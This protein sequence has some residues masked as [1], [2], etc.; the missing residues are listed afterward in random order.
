M[1]MIKMPKMWTKQ[2]IKRTLV[3]TMRAWKKAVLLCSTSA[4]TWCS[5]QLE[6][7]ATLCMAAEVHKSTT[8]ADFR[9]TNESWQV[10]EFTN[11][12]FTNNEDDCVSLK[13]ANTT[14]SQKGHC[15]L[16]GTMF[17]SQLEGSKLSLSVQS[18]FSHSFCQEMPEHRGVWACHS[19]AVANANTSTSPYL[20]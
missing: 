11:M 6:F 3:D 4:G 19:P 16:K 7:F 15:C 12:E 10:G 5:G 17:W 13:K 20:H 2:T 8:K 14:R 1:K 9:V 18:N